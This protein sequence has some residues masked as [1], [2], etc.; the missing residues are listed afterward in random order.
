MR[1]FFVLCCGL[2]ISGPALAQ[3]SLPNARSGNT[4][5]G[6]GI[7][8]ETIPVVLPS[9]SR[10]LAPR[11]NGP[12]LFPEW[13]LGKLSPY[14]GPPTWAWVKYNLFDHQLISGTIV[15]NILVVKPIDTDLLRQFTLGD[16]ARGLAIVLRRYVNLRIAK[17]SLRTAFFEVHYDSGRTALLCQRYVVASGSVLRYYLK[18]EGNTLTPI[19]LKAQSVL[20][21]LGSAQASALATYA[22]EHALNLTRES[23][24]VRLLQYYDAK[25]G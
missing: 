17:P 10:G 1:L 22:R 24:V 13:T 19:S 9:P 11:Y 8:P 5:S 21:A 20:A 23:D 2:A 16:S 12:Y 3:S 7:N 18:A 4:G 25:R 15:D 6:P 14:V